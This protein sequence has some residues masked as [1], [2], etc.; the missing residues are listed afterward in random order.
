MVMNMKKILVKIFAWL[1]E[2]IACEQAMYEALYEDRIAPLIDK[3]LN[4]DS[5]IAKLE[6]ELNTLKAEIDSK[7]A[8][9]EAPT[10]PKRKYN[11]RKKAD[12][13]A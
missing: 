8:A 9:A 11:K 4:R 10:K 2:S 12:D 3:V 6:E 5:R 1:S 13:K 7:K